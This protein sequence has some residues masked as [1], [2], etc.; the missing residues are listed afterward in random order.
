M[1]THALA[2]KTFELERKKQEM[3]FA[4][5]EFHGARQLFAQLRLW[6]YSKDS[7]R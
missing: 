2:E 4:V 6:E 3:L 1:K 5:R 7:N